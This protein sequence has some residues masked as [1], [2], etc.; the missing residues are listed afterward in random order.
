MNLILTM[1]GAVLVGLLA[2][3]PALVQLEHWYRVWEFW[4]R[5]L[6]GA[7]WDFV[8]SELGAV[9]VSYFIR[10]PGVQINGSTTAP[11]A[12]QAAQVY[13]QSAVVVFGVTSDAQ[14]LF[15]HNWGLDVSAPTFY[16]PELLMVAALSLNT[17][18]PAFTF[19][20]TNSNVFIVNKAATDAPTKVL[21]TLRRPHSLGQ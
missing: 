16:E 4:H 9:T 2:S 12:T 10:G 1:F 15:T 11:T 18:Q 20:W 13:K 19:D 14:A 6:R 7:F 21:I 3:M 17:Y 5:G 8:G